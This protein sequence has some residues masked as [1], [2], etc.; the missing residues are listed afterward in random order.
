MSLSDLA[1]L[2]S[3]VSGVAVLA[4]LIYLTLQ[5]RQS[6]RNQRAI[7]QQARA[8]Q[9]NDWNL[10]LADATLVESYYKGAYG[11]DDISLGQFRQFRMAFLAALLNLENSFLQHKAHL[12]S[13]DV[14]D[15]V[16]SNAKI[17][18]TRPG[19]RAMW[20]Q[21]RSM[22]GTDFGRFLDQIISE[23]PVATPRDDLAD[24]MAAVVAEKKQAAQ[25]A[26]PASQF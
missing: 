21:S 14:F 15:G 26:D 3:F 22:H 9:L 12:I 2:G 7:A 25:V 16:S 13:D 1:S 20:K 19:L 23:T 10:R 8:S 11:D 18:F 24:W 6:E 17:I 5:V 4:S